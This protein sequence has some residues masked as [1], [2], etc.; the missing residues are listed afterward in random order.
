MPEAKIKIGR[1]PLN[2]AQ[3]MTVRVAL[4]HFLSQLD[5]T[6]FSRDLGDDQDRLYKR[7][8]TEIN[9][10]IVITQIEKKHAKP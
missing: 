5:D 10:M 2:T 1:F 7:R 3:S 9:E 4:Q 6:E 8:L